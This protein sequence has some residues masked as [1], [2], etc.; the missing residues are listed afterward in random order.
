[1]GYKLCLSLRSKGFYLRPLGDVVVLM[2]PLTATDDELRRLAASLH[3]VLVE[4][5]GP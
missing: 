3:A 5:F 2:P 1:V 4:R